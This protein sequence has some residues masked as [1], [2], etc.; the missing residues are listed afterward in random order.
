VARPPARSFLDRPIA[1][2]LALCVALLCA[3][4][5]GWLH[6]ADLLPAAFAPQAADD[7]FA[8]CF[9][10]RS[11]EIDAMVEE[12]VVDQARA[13]LFKSRAEAMCRTETQT[14]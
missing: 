12:G 13:E 8:R 4:A 6:R 9:A 2:V 5:L 1:R 11:A 3:G 7:P 10:E 14:P